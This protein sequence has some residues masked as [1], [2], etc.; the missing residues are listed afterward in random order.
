MLRHM[1]SEERLA[2]RELFEKVGAQEII[3][4]VA[5]L[6]AN[7]VADPSNASDLRIELN[8]L[9][10]KCGKALGEKEGQRA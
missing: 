1:T 2:M 6:V 7:N 3:G 9:G 5:G 10:L 8:K 4:V